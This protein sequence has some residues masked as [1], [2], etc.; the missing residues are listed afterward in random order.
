MISMRVWAAILYLNAQDWGTRRIARELGISRNKVKRAIR[1]HSPPKYQRAPKIN[2]QLEP[3]RDEITSMLVQKEFIGSR[4]MREI[5]KQGYQGSQAAFYRFL[6]KPKDGF[7]NSKVTERFEIPPGKQ[8][9]FDWSPYTV[10]MGKVL[11]RVI[12]FC[13][14]LSYSRR[15]HYS[16]NPDENQGS[17][18]EALEESFHHFGGVPKETLIDNPKALVL[19]PRPDLQWNPQVPGAL[20]T[21]PL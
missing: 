11:T 8:G 10:E 19:K 21:L 2:P 16:A 13:H 14:I 3:F 7:P 1:A 6:K 15:K 17:I 12:L 9:Q 5:R 20:R 18:F 4:I